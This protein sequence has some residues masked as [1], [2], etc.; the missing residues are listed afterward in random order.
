MLGSGWKNSAALLQVQVENETVPW[1]NTLSAQTEMRKLKMAELETIYR[2]NENFV[3]RQIEGETILV[4]IRGNVSD[5]D[6]IYSLNPIGA[7]VWE[8][9]DGSA[10]LKEIQ[11][12]ITREYEVSDDE[13]EKDLLAFIEEMK[14]ISALE[15]AQCR[16]QGA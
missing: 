6:C 16:S 15:V 7:L 13:A 12:L 2:R 1:Y 4:P 9:L 10:D 5:L 3:F 11:K 8:H 14:S